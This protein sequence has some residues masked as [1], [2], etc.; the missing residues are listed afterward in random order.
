MRLLSV[1]AQSTMPA[2][3]CYRNGAGP[4]EVAPRQR[5]GRRSSDDWRQVWPPPEFR[6]QLGAQATSLVTQPSSTAGSGCHGWRQR[7]DV[8]SSGA[9]LSMTVSRVSKLM[10]RTTSRADMEKA[11]QMDRA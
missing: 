7:E 11:T 9:T 10:P 3:S 1:G 2:G 8:G 5:H 6:P 4:S